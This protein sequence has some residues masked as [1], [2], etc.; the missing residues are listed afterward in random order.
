MDSTAA[1]DQLRAADLY[2]RQIEEGL[3]GD[4]GAA[5]K[6]RMVVRDLLDGPVKLMPRA[7][8]TLWAEFALRPAALLTSNNRL[9]FSGSGGRI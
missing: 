5:Q 8:G 1:V 4:P 7:D 3:S 6:G 2:R 9:G